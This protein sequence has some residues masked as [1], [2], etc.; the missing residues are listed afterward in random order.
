LGF[1]LFPRY[2][3]PLTIA[4]SFTVVM[5]LG[6]IRVLRVSGL[7]LS[8]A[9]ALVVMTHAVGLYWKPSSEVVLTNMFEAQFNSPHDVFIFEPIWPEA[10]RLSLPL[11]STS[12][13]LLNNRQQSMSRYQFLLQHLDTVDRFVPFK[14]IVV[15][16]D[17]TS[18]ETAYRSH[19][20]SPTYTVWTITSE[21][22]ALCSEAE[23]RTGACFE[24]N[25]GACGAFPQDIHML[26]DFLSYP[27]LGGAYIV[28][29]TE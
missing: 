23:T 19:F 12:L 24:V 22:S 2:S 9:L 27:K 26:K 21:C 28:R 8:G 5:L 11:N 29:K 14:S 16:P 10:S 4:F 15:M 25:V 13:P 20:A 3:L 1:G 6:E 17:T 7:I 18:E